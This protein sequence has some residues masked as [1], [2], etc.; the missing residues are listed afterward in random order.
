MSHQSKVLLL[1]GIIVDHYFEVDRYPASG[2]DAIILNSFDKIGGCAL[3]VGVTL[4]NLGSIPYVVSK[5][6]DDTV[7]QEIAHYVQSI[8]IPTSCLAIV[9]GGKTGYC[10]TILDQGGERTFLTYKGVEK[11]FSADS[12]PNDLLQNISFI[13]ITGYYLL[14]RQ[15]TAAVLALVKQLKRAE[16]Q[17]L[18]DPGPLVAHIDPTQLQEVIALSDWTI[19]NS[20]ELEFIQQALKFKTDPVKWLLDQGCQYVAVKKGAKGADIYSV[21]STFSFKGFRVKTVDTTGAG[22]SFAGGLI[23]ALSN[24]L[25]AT[26]AI[27]FASACGAYTATIEGPHGFF[28]LQEIEHFITSHKDGI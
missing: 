19:P 10:H 6:G 1:G 14:N 20:S 5:L 12:L 3:N 9:P 17:I 13:Y 2:Q 7:G 16:C 23:H 18:F 22:D 27:E 21:A 25:P 11:E 26:Q 24:Q 4:H 8:P 28:T 15:S